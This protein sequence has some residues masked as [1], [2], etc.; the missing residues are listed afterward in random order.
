MSDELSAIQ[1]YTAVEQRRGFEVGGTLD[2]PASAVHGSLDGKLS[3][4]K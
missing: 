1:S 3:F 2:T 4:K